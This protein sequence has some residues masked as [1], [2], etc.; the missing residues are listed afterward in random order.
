MIALDRQENPRTADAPQAPKPPL[1]VGLLLDSYVQPQWVHRI[2]SDILSSQAAELVVVVKNEAADAAPQSSAR[3]K[4][5]LYKAYCRMDARLFAEKPD[6]LERVSIE[7]LI[8]KVPVVSVKPIMKKFSDELSAADAAALAEYSLDVVLRFGFRIL[9]G[10][11]LRLPKYGVWSYH[12]GD[13]TRYRGGPPGFWEV[14]EGR[15]ATGAVLQILSEEL[16]NGAV[17]C[18]SFAETDSYSVSRNVNRYY[19]Q[20]SAFVLRK[21]CDLH[22]NGPAV[23]ADHS[24]EAWMPYSG[25][26]YRWPTNGQMCRLLVRLGRRYL[27]AK[28]K[29]ALYFRQWFL[30]YRIKTGEPGMDGTFYRFKHLV[31]PKDRFW[32]DPFSVKK[33]GKYYIF[34]EELLY[35]TNKGHLSVIE[36]D[37]KG[38]VSGPHTILDRPYHLSYPCVFTWNGTFYMVPESGRAGR[39]DLFRCVA[40]PERWEFE[41]TLLSGL[42]AVDSTVAQLEGRWWMFVSVQVPGAKHIYELHLYHADSPLGPWSPHKNNPVRPDAHASRPAGHVFEKNGAYYRPVQKGP[43]SGMFLYRI[44]RLSPDEFQETPIC[45]ITPEW[46]ENL[47][48]THTLNYSDGLTVI[49]GLLEKR[50]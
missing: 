3:L 19:W 40:F 16:D 1:R 41:A 38:I 50:R 48:G 22:Q 10:Q 15:P 26:L 14:M 47:V 4:F 30:A 27:A 23:L 32:A 5:F 25:R 34:F 39:V 33:D 31:P 12:H 36:V 45:E 42:H 46:A 49:D 28:I 43:G 7:P 29:H 13:N 37:Q 6:A 17:I 35:K 44:D 21:L 24:A 9:K 11:I 2:V 20:A 18:R 8:A